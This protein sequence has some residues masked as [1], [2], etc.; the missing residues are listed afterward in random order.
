[1]KQ[2]KI[3]CPHCGES[4]TIRQKD[5][6]DVPQDMLAEVSDMI[7][8]IFKGTDKLFKKAFDPKNWR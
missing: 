7:G 6:T 1:M 8:E 2:A 5:G 4:I 3:N